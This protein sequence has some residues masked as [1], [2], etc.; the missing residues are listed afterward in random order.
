MNN[1]KIENIIDRKGI[2]GWGGLGEGEV[3][4]ALT[5]TFRFDSFE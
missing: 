2:E 4:N 1:T 5:K 3:D